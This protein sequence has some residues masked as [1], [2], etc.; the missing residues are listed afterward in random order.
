MDG[1]S[2]LVFVDAIRSTNCTLQI[3]IVAIRSWRNSIITD[4]T[5]QMCLNKL[6]Q[7]VPQKRLIDRISDQTD[8]KEL[9][10]RCSFPE[11]WPIY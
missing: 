9:E 4:P 10:N 2:S 8:H 5:I 6:E 7:S 3:Q 1:L 11:K